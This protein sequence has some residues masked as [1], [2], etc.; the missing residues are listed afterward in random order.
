[1]TNLWGGGPPKPLTEIELKLVEFAAADCSDVQMAMDLGLS[2]NA[3]EK[4]WAKLRRRFG[5]HSRTAIIANHFQQRSKKLEEL[6]NAHLRLEDELALALFAFDENRRVVYCNKAAARLLGLPAE[7]LIGNDRVWRQV[8][9][10]AAERTRIRREFLDGLKDFFRHVT[11]ITR[12]DGTVA[13]VAW[14]SRARSHPIHPYH[15]WVIGQE[16][17]PRAEDSHR[18]PWNRN[19]HSSS[20]SFRRATA[21]FFR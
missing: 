6:Y 4:R 21:S 12:P 2:K 11:R 1:M 8:T 19:H 5:V 16:I 15:W 18:E 17:P 7:D 3:V 13:T 9:P 10:G 20:N 14:S